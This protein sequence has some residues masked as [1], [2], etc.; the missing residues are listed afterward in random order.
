MKNAFD[1]ILK[2]YASGHRQTH[3]CSCGPASVNLVAR[4]FGLSEVR[5]SD[6]WSSQHETWANVVAFSNRGMTINELQMIAELTYGSKIEIAFRRAYPENFGLFIQD[7]ERVSK[8]SSEAIV[9]NYSQDHA[10]NRT[11]AP[12]GNPHHSPIAGIDFE[13]KQILIADVD[14]DVG[15]SYWVGFNRAFEAMGF[16]NPAFRIP[17]GWLL[18]RNRSSL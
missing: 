4:A 7:L 11:I 6:W 1:Q 2:I 15:T 14:P 18:I 5:E 9:L 10:R 3:P 16:E 13:R 12:H 17:R 8:S